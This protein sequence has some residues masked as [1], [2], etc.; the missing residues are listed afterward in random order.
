L[1]WRDI[2][3]DARVLHVRQ[4]LID[5]DGRISFGGPKTKGSAAGVG[6]SGR[7]VAALRVQ[8]EQQLAER[9]EWAEAYEDHDLVFARENGKP[10]RPEWV[11]DTFHRLSREAGLREVTLHDLRHL[12][13]TLMITNGVP[14]P[15]VSKTLRHSKVGITA[16]LYRHLTHE[17]SVAAA[18]ALG[19]VLDAVASERSAIRR[20][21]MRPQCDRSP[22]F[23]TRR[24]P[25]LTLFPLVRTRMLSPDC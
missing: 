3:L 20:R 4:N 10:L 16:D 12:A 23:R 5:I 24:M 6:L 22:K 11:L 14:L 15:L 17:A 9:A 19:S 1:R 25:L 13:A 8:R 7:V 2:D 18:D 21:R